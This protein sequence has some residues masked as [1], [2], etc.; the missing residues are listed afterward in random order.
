M[1]GQQV[2]SVLPR[3]NGAAVVHAQLAAAIPGYRLDTVSPWRAAL[4]LLLGPVARA[5]Y[6]AADVVHVVPDCGVHGVPRDT[7]CVATFHNLFTDDTWLAQVDT[8]RRLYYRTVLRRAVAA[9]VRRAD[10]LVAVSRYTR[11]IAR[12]ATGARQID[13]ILNG[14]D[15]TLFSPGP[16]RADDG[17]CRLLFVGNP[18]RRKGFDLVEALADALPANCVIHYTSGL[19]DVSVAARH[20]RLHPVPLTPHASM[21]DVYRAADMLFFP[22]RREGLSLAVLEAM[23]CGLPVVSF[24][25]SSLA[26][27]IDHGR[28][29][30]LLAPGDRD[31]LLA[32]IRQCASSPQ[33]R[34]DMGAWNRARALRDFALP[35]ML[36]EYA[37]LFGESSR[38]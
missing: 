35:R 10:R 6:A 13:V 15:T 38:A 21:P 8:A 34:A 22:T 20:P 32:A 5:A 33:R 7:P 2:R 27:Q 23:A 24:N 18:S 36:D 3:G 37:A 9:T 4:P 25:A 31:G 29:G 12:Q 1:S 16:P 11:D 30:L 19:R 14:V 26:E 17:L 28:G